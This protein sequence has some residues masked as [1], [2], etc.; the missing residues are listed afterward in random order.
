[1]VPAPITSLAIMERTWSACALLHNIEYTEPDDTKGNFPDQKEFSFEYGTWYKVKLIYIPV[2]REKA[3]VIIYQA[4]P[5]PHYVS[6]VVTTTD[7]MLNFLEETLTDTNSEWKVLNSL[8][9][10]MA[11]HQ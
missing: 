3:T 6:K 8:L 1:M 7:E 2:A 11:D 4:N 5:K 10:L 9:D